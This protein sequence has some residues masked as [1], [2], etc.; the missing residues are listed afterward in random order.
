MTKKVPYKV[1]VSTEEQEVTIA[2]T[3]KNDG[4]MIRTEEVDG[5]GNPQLYLIRDEMEFIILKM[6]EMMDYLEKK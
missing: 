3:E 1:V 6:R 2:P 4:I 5:S